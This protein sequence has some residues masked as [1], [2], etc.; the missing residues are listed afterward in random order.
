MKHKWRPTLGDTARALVENDV[1]DQSSAGELADALDR[2]ITELQ[3]GRQ[4]PPMGTAADDGAPRASGSCE[5]LREENDD[6]RKALSGVIRLAE[7]AERQNQIEVKR[8]RMLGEQLERLRHL[9]ANL[10]GLV[11]VKIEGDEQAARIRSDMERVNGAFTALFETSSERIAA[12][13]TELGET[14]R[15]IARDLRTARETAEGPGGV[16]LAMAVPA[17]GEAERGDGEPGAGEAHAAE[18]ADA[19]RPAAEEKARAAEREAQAKGAKGRG[20]GGMER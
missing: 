12:E 16:A 13:E 14:I 9:F 8:A 19:A 6:L 15:Q 2:A 11:G 3:S 4:T 18:E 1:D 20:K 7:A 17:Q 10:G 5:A